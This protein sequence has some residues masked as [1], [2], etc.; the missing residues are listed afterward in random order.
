MKN[1]IFAAVAAVSEGRSRNN[2]VRRLSEKKEPSHTP[3]FSYIRQQRPAA[4]QVS[5]KNPS[6]SSFPSS[7]IRLKSRLEGAASQPGL[8]ERPTDGSVLFLFLLLRGSEC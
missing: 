2:N 1:N 5:S 4:S 6:S 8:L 3:P 7:L